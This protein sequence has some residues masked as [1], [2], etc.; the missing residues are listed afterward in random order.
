MYSP[1]HR[2]GRCIL[3]TALNERSARTPPP[4]L[5]FLSSLVKEQISSRRDKKKNLEHPVRLPRQSPEASSPAPQAV[6]AVDEDVLR[7]PGFRVNT[8]SE[9]FL[10]FFECSSA[11]CSS[12]H[13]KIVLRRCFSSELYLSRR[14]CP[15]T[16]I[17]ILRQRSRQVPQ[18]SLWSWAHV[19]CQR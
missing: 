13:S 9:D 6:A 1:K 15:S 8:H 3:T 10:N 19:S 16:N 17:W 7:E 5:L 14:L 4:T 2:L 18:I 11:P 12:R